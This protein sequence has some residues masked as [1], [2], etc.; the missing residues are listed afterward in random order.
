MKGN[1]SACRCR[2]W[3][4]AASH[5]AVR[6]SEIEQEKAGRD[7]WDGG[8]EL[9]KELLC[10]H[11]NRDRC[12]RRREVGQT[13][14]RETERGN[15]ERERAAWIQYVHS[16]A[17]IQTQHARVNTSSATANLCSCQQACHLAFQTAIHLPAE[18]V[19]LMSPIH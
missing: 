9:R 3:G 19:M 15:R 16:W 4:P 7:P 1:A 8:T 11:L 5:H 17:L 14:G 2:V 12:W 13:E 10:S 6:I 18:N